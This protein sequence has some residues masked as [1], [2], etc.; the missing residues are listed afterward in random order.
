MYYNF[1]HYNF[2]PCTIKPKITVII[3]IEIFAK[4]SFGSFISSIVANIKENIP[5]GDNLF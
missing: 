3:N 4:T 1:H 2:K 5:I